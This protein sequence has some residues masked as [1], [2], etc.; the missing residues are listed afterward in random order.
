MTS[1]HHKV[2]IFLVVAASTAL[3]ACSFAPRYHPPVE[4]AAASYKEAA[5]AGPAT[6][7]DVGTWSPAQPADDRTRG[8]WWEVFGDP[9]LDDLERRAGASNQTIAAAAARYREARAVADAAATQLLPA[10]DLAASAQ[11]QRI[12]PNAPTNRTGAPELNSDYVLRAQTS[13]ELDFWGRVRN[14]NAAARS[15]AEA[16]RADLE[17]ATLSIQSELADDYIILRG[18]DAQIALLETTVAAYGEALRITKDRYQGG[19][20]AVVDVDQAATQFAVARVQ[21][22]DT[23]LSR[24]QMEHAIAIL[25]GEQPANFSIASQPLD[26]SLPIVTPGL[27]SRLLE[28]RPD[29]ASAERRM[30]AANAEIGIA[31]AAWLPT[32]SLDAGIGY[33]GDKTS[34]W[35]E[36]PSRI[37]SVGPSMLFNVFDWGLRRAQNKRA[38]AAF[39]EAAANYRQAVLTAYGQVEDQLAAVRRLDAALDAQQRAVGSSQRALDQ[40]NYRYKGGISTYLEVVTAQNAALQARQ[41]DLNLRVRRLNASVQLIK[42]LGGGWTRAGLAASSPVESHVVADAAHRPEATP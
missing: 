16:G 40:A 2:P 12:S 22:E 6:Q 14:T 25:V 1:T 36:A 15:R 17:T 7:N 11:R 5:A 41:T 38:F 30:F 24:A 39:D 8:A 3:S 27:P 28:R 35:I 29:V 26:I 21:L 31:R 23:R 4:I 18:L 19:A 34:N 37:W 20:I 13:Y 9:Q 32:F 33:E 42:A 10:I